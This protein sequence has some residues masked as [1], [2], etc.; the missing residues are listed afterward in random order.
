MGQIADSILQFLE[1]PVSEIL[2]SQWKW[3]KSLI[4]FYNFQK[5]RRVKSYFHIE[6]WGKSQI[7]FYNFHTF[8]TWGNGP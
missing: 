8:I 7:P 1:I 4:P 3:G 6:K 2:F 5:L